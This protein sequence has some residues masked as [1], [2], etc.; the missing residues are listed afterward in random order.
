MEI[1]KETNTAASKEF[2]KL[3]NNQISKTKN[4][5]EGKIVE[6]IVTKVSEKYIFLFIEG[7]KSEP[8]V[9]IN[10]IKTL[11][12]ESKLKVGEKIQ[13]LLERIEDKNGEV[14]VSASK[15][16][17]IK[18]WDILVK[19]FE[20]NEPIMGKITSKCKGGVIVEHIDT[21]SLMFCPGSQ[22]SDIPVKDISHLINEPQ[23]F[24]LIKMDKVRGN[25]CVSRR[26]IISSGKKEDKAKIIEKYKEGDIIK[27]AVVK[28][29]SSFGCFF[30]VNNELDCLVHLQEISYSRVNHPEEVF[31]IGDKHDLLVI[32]VDKDKLQIGCS[33]KQLSPDPFDK[34]SNYELNKK[35]QAKVIKI[36][37]FGV[38]AELEPGLTTLLHSSEISWS[39]K[40]VSPKKIFK[41]GEKI[42]C[43]ITE[44]DKEKRR[45]AISYRLTKENPFDQLEKNN[46]VG[47]EVSGTI[48]SMNEYAIYL[49][50]DNYE[51]DA[52]LH[53]ND[54]SFTGVPEEVA[55]NYK[56]KDK[57]TV[58][59]LEIKKDL[60]KLR[61]GLKQTQKDPF[62][63]FKDKK[64]NDT[65]TVKVLSSDNKGLTVQPEGCDLNLL[66][67]KSQI[68][69]S[70][71]DARPSRFV[72]GERIDAAI[73]EL[74]HEKRKVTL[75]IKLLEELQNKE[76]VSKFS[77][78][79]S[80]KNLPF[81]SLSDKLS[82][83]KEKK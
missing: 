14:V 61:V 37:D 71:T 67:K 15:A 10:E 36:M 32:S 7:L 38:F 23:K 9:D 12:Q 82:N 73:S 42:D 20:N 24:A 28:G 8:L 74:N 54:L 6:G 44:V 55:K 48:S 64:I 78:P 77:S 50:L 75:S 25:A 35:Y 26:Q 19:A 56:L 27:N 33:I 62:E 79:L 34:I 40:N 22:I 3:L 31:N 72:G 21:G 76:A 57:L 53:F 83:K 46:P 81:S 45:I 52:F 59:V 18:G 43:V 70:T 41:V 47:T 4:L 69:V 51:I 68:A 60:Q 58:K 66:I 5:T 30:N 16:Q 11:G 17:K 80:G 1:Y 49:K 29:Y 13:V 2:E 65:V 63:Y 39:R